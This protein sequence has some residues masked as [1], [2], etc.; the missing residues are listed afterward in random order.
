MSKLDIARQITDELVMNDCLNIADHP[1]MEALVDEVSD[2][3]LDKLQEYTIII[4]SAI[5]I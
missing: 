1:N 3:I 2:I 4:T 5:L